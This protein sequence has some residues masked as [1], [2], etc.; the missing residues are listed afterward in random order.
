MKMGIATVPVAAIASRRW[1]FHVRT[2][3]AN[4]VLLAHSVWSARRRPVRARRARSPK[5]KTSHEQH[6]QRSPRRRRHVADAVEPL[7][8]SA[9]VTHVYNPLSY[10]WAVHEQYLKK[11]AATPKRILFLGMN[12]GPFGMAQTGVPFRRSERRARLDGP[13]RPRAAPGAR[14]SETPRARLRLPALRSERPAFVGLFAQRFGT[15][16]IFFRDTSS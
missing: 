16:E 4:G 13:A 10:A 9:P 8:F 7:K 3:N 2:P 15:P 14:A 11:F 6:R 5:Q 12:P 1:H